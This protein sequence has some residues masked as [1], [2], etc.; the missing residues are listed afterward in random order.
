[1]HRTFVFALPLERFPYHCVLNS[2]LQKN[3]CSVRASIRIYT[4][5][6][7]HQSQ[8]KNVENRCTSCGELSG[9]VEKSRL[10]EAV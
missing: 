8:S 3:L 7:V 10:H 9:A 6:F 5:P 1:M 2:R 4:Y